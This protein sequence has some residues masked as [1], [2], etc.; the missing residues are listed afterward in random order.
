MKT[1]KELG[2]SQIELDAML[3]VRALLA[4]YPSEQIE[5]VRDYFEIKDGTLTAMDIAP[6]TEDIYTLDGF[7]GF[8]MG[9]TCISS[10][11]DQIR[12][13]EC[14]TVGCIAGWMGVFM[15]G[16]APVEGKPHIIPVELAH[17]INRYVQ[18]FDN[19]RPYSFN[20]YPQQN[21]NLYRLFF[22]DIEEWDIISPAEAVK[23]IDNYLEYGEALWREIDAARA[24]PV[25]QQYESGEV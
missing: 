20:D 5:V 21:E 15:W 10:V 17:K 13:Y 6:I 8:N 23:A 4:T 7:G 16:E 25:M 24:N 3:K 22:P 1:A 14:G 12:G 18:A 9:Q 2:L 19:K 11:D